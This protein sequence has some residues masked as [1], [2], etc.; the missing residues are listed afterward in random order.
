MLQSFSFLL[1][2]AGMFVFVGQAFEAFLLAGG[3]A[4]GRSRELLCLLASF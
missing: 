4:G 2:D 3:R 1:A